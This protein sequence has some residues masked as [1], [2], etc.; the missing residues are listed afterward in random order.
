M[1]TV[2]IPSAGGYEKLIIQKAPVLEPKDDEVVIKT[3]A[4][5]INYADICVRWGI[6]ES[7]KKFVGWPITPGF[8]FAGDIIKVGSNV[9]GFSEGEKVFGVTLFNGYSG[10]I[11]VNHKHIF[12][13]PDGYSYE[14]MASFPA[15]FL[16]AYHGLFQNFC[17]F[18]DMNILI[19]SAAGGV[20]GAL[21]QLSRYAN[22]NTVGVVGRSEK[23]LSAQNFGATHVIDKSITKWDKQAKSIFPEGYDAIFDANGFATLNDSFKLLRPTGKLIVYGFHSMLPKKGGKI[24]WVKLAWNYIKTPKFNPM[25]LTTTNKSVMAFNLSFL[26]DRDDLFI[27]AM[28]HLIELLETKQISPHPVTSYKIDDVAK[29]HADIESGKTT[30]KL[31]LSH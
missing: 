31:V 17:T 25:D 14:Q 15:V 27:S 8:E 28:N 24:N 30:G 5:G 18:K 16:T 20:G 10:C 4:S 11:K 26:F 12:K 21:L 3:K 1:K 29:A 6:Y 19:H 7:A 13:I 23:V 9:T 2:V 22:F